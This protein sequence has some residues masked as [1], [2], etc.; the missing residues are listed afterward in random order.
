M[1]YKR[2]EI[3]E[4]GGPEVLGIV[5][6]EILPEPGKGEV[7]VRVLSAGAS[8]TDIMI[9]KGK[10]PEVKRKP[11]FTIGYDMVGVVD[12]VGEGVEHFLP[13]R[14]VADLTVIGACAEYICIPADR[15]TPVPETVDPAEAVCLVLS[16]V[17]AYQ[18]LH[19]IARVKAGGRILIHGAGGAVGT[20]MI[21]LC[22]LNGIEVYGTASE[23]KHELVSG[24]GAVPID[25][26]KEDFA[27]RIDDLAKGG[28]DAV[29]DPIGGD[30][31][32]RSLRILRPGGMLVCYGFYNS[33]LGKGGSVPLDFL[34][35]KLWNILPIQRSTAFYSIGA[36]RKKHPDWFAEDLAVLFDLLENGKIRPVI[37]GRFPMAEAAKA[38]ERIETGQVNGKLILEVS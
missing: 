21:Q 31:L 14:M 22:R 23:S 19:R 35:L 25:Y 17:T 32:K 1:T 34:R 2:L 7:R 27:E 11:P 24:L 37:G 8:F 4:F 30:T 13:G 33:V 16:Y 28:V 36:T 29:F 38:Y 12:K 26:R 10:Y 15:L 9:R 3:A 6:E 5:E 18:M 20:A